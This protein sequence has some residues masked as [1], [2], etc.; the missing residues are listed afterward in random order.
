MTGSAPI[1]VAPTHPAARSSFDQ[2]ETLL[3]SFDPRVK[4]IHAAG[5]TGVLGFDNTKPAF[6]FPHILAQVID[7]AADMVQ[8]PQH[9]AFTIGHVLNYNTSF[10][11]RKLF[12]LQ[13]VRHDGVL[14]EP[15]HL[16]LLVILE[17]ALEPFDMAV[18]F[19]G[20]D[21]RG[22]AVGEPAVMAD[23]DGAAGG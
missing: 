2:F 7:R 11:A 14:A 9:K 21:V 15:P 20:Q 6:D 12:I 10:L 16:V 1:R 18:A 19:E 13:P 5:K 17:I 23:D 22:D 8:V 3:N 4:A